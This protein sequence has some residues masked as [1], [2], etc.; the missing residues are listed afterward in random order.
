MKMWTH[1]WRTIKNGLWFTNLVSLTKSFKTEIE[2]LVVVVVDDFARFPF[3]RRLF[4]LIFVVD[5]VKGY[6]PP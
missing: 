4:F 2:E 6:E 5:S 3:G 1:N